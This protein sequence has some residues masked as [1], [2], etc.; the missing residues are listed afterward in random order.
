MSVIATETK[1]DISEFSPWIFILTGC[2]ALFI[3]KLK[4]ATNTRPSL[5][6]HERADKERTEL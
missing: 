3:V 2:D 4:P 1:D 5:N 6:T